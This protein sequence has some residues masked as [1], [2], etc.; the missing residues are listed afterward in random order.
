MT[1]K[2][3]E[4]LKTV[5]ADTYGLYVKTQNYHWNIKGPH[6]YSLHKLLE[7]QYDDLAGAIDEIAERIVILGERAPGSFKEYQALMTLSEAAGH[8]QHYQEMV[9][10][11]AQAQGDL[12][13][14]L[15]K[16]L[17]MAQGVGDEVTAGLMADRLSVHEKNKWMLDA[18]LTTQ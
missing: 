6:F 17:E 15:Q 7:D 2:V 10:D 8:I 14:T 4:A 13:K 11:L 3:S 12:C 9:H 16:T 1:K 5:L 18:T